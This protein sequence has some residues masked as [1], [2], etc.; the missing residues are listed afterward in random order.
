M[1]KR[2]LK[3]VKGDYKIDFQLEII[4]ERLQFLNGCPVVNE[5]K[6]FKQLLF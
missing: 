2:D 6:V 1:K 3:H 4:K 5:N